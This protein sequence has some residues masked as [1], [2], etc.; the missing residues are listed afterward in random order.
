MNMKISDRIDSH[1]GYVIYKLIY[2]KDY[3]AWISL[4]GRVNNTV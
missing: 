3:Y 2:V 1:K 4:F